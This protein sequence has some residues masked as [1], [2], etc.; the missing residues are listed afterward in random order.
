MDE[1]KNITILKKRDYKEADEH[2]RG[3]KFSDTD[4]ASDY[5]M[6]NGMEKSISDS[7]FGSNNELNCVFDLNTEV[8]LNARSGH[9]E[10]GESKNW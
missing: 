8:E 6:N 3:V 5:R 9:T 2:A 7:A 10:D 4:E 1:T